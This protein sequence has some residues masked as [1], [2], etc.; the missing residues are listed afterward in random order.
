MK[1]SLPYAYE[2]TVIRTGET[3]PQ[4]RIVAA[5]RPFLGELSEIAGNLAP[6]AFRVTITTSTAS[7]RRPELRWYDERL[8]APATDLTEP[9]RTAD[10]ITLAHADRE[11]A[12]HF[13]DIVGDELA[14]ADYASRPISTYLATRTRI[15]NWLDQ[16]LLIDGRLYAESNE[17]RY[18]AIRFP[19]AEPSLTANIYVTYQNAEFDAGVEYGYFAA[20]ALSEAREFLAEPTLQPA[21]RIEILLPHAVRYEEGSDLRSQILAP[22]IPAHIGEHP[23]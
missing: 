7:A 1:V 15:V 16:H 9:V 20:N 11:L 6:V 3:R 23:R 17:P 13:P 2:V 5:A 21:S 10:V 4:T 18:L 8:W 22:M 19:N 12:I 14:L